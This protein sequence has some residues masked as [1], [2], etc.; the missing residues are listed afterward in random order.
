[1][2]DTG[3]LFLCARCRV[4]VLI[5]SACDR[6]QIYC[7]RK[8]SQISRHASVC[9]A[10]RRY[11]R[12]FKG[13]LAHAKRSR[14]Y[15]ERQKNVTHQGSLSPAADDLLAVDPAVAVASVT[16]P[17]SSTPCCRFCDMQLSAFVRIGYLGGR[18]P[19]TI[20]QHNHKGSDYDH[21]P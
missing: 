2:Q 9:A 12:T 21:S 17:R 16:L 7:S 15:R 8:C 4:Q 11:Q 1:M 18:V 14:R 5:C 6:G 10:G 19:R 20:N 13:R 3:R